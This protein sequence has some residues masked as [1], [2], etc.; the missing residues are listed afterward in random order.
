MNEELDDLL[1][2]VDGAAPPDFEAQVMRR[3][4]SLPLPQR[5]ARWSTLA[6]RLAFAAAVALGASQ[7]VTFIFGLWAVTAAADA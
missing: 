3:I 6:Q 1:H 2:A 7:V 4:A 5:P